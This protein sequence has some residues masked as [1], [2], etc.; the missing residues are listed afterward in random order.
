[1][2]YCQDMWYLLL[3]PGCTVL[4]VVIVAEMTMLLAFSPVTC[5]LALRTYAIQDTARGAYGREAVPTLNHL[6]PGIAEPVHNDN[7]P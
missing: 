6:L 1:M 2:Q 5:I 4:A 3:P 7:T